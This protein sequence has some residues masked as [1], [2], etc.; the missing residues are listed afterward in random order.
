M[1]LAP[2]VLFVYNRPTLTQSTLQHLSENREAGE[3]TLYVYCDGAKEG[4]TAAQLQLIKEVRDIVHSK[5]WCKEVVIYEATKNKGLATSVIDGVT[6]VI[7]KHGKIIV[8][9]DDLT[10]S[11]FFLKFM[12]DGLTRYEQEEKVMAVHG[13]LYPFPIP[14]DYT[15]S[16]FLVHDPGSL[17]WGTWSRAWNKFERDTD[18]VIAGIK[19]KGLKAAFDFWGAYPFFRMLHQHKNGKVSSWAIR[20]RATAYLHDMFTL[21]PVKSLVRHDGNVA[22][23]THHFKEEDWLYTDIYQHPVAVD[24]I[25]V[26]NNLPMEKLFAKFLRAN[27]G[28]TVSAKIKN[29]LKKYWR[30]ITGHA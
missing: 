14:A 25:P 6:E 12:N 11:P 17:G 13:Y 28:M 24:N 16:T 10:V 18:T 22:G 8:L 26:Q 23:A 15:A 2:I 7:S 29:R 9:E 21:Y 4:A 1:A 30:K 3:S 19:A 20:W 5:Q 27:A